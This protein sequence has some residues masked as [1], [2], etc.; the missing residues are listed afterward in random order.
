MAF[1]VSSNVEKDQ[2]ELFAI[3]AGDEKM[4]AHPEAR[5]QSNIVPEACETSISCPDGSWIYHDL[6]RGYWTSP[7]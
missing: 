3:E 5:A 1:P 2:V 6:E 7:P 4:E